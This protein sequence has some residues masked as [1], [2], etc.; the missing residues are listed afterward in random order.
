M[1]VIYLNIRKFLD[2]HI[3]IGYIIRSLLKTINHGHIWS[4]RELKSTYVSSHMISVADNIEI[5]L[6]VNML[7]FANLLGSAVGGRRGM[8]PL[9]LYVYC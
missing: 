8:H 5:S 3:E 4:P 2:S 6:Q 7:L 9:Q 1:Y